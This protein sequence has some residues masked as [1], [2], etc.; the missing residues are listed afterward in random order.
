MNVRCFGIPNSTLLRFGNLVF[1]CFLAISQ[2]S[3]AYLSADKK[4]S[5][6]SSFC[7][8]S[9]STRKTSSIV[10]AKA[11]KRNPTSETFKGTALEGHPARKQQGDTAESD[12]LLRNQSLEAGSGGRINDSMISSDNASEIKENSMAEPVQ[13]YDENDS[14]RLEDWI[15]SKAFVDSALNK[16]KKVKMKEIKEQ[17]LKYFLDSNVTIRIQQNDVSDVEFNKILEVPKDVQIT[18][19]STR[20]LEVEEKILRAEKTL[21]KGKSKSTEPLPAKL[22]TVSAV[23]QVNSPTVSDQIQSNSYDISDATNLGF[24]PS[25]VAENENQATGESRFQVQDPSKSEKKLST[26]NET[27]MKIINPIHI[28]R[29]TD[30]KLEPEQQGRQQQQQDRFRTNVEEISVFS[31]STR[32][33]CPLTPQNLFDFAV[34]NEII[35]QNEKDILTPAKEDTDLKIKENILEEND[36]YYMKVRKLNED[37][38]T[39]MNHKNNHSD[40][41]NNIND[42]NDTDN[43]GINNKKE[44]NEELEMMKIFSGVELWD[45]GMMD[46]WDSSE[47][48][49]FSDLRRSME[50][51]SSILI[52]PDPMLCS[53]SETIVY[54]NIDIDIDIDVKTSTNVSEHRDNDSKKLN[55]DRNDYVL[56]K[57]KGGK[58]KKEER[59]NNYE[60][61]SSKDDYLLFNCDDKD[62][63][64][65]KNDEK[66]AGIINEDEKNYI[67]TGD[68]TNNILRN[69]SNVEN[70][71]NK[72]MIDRNDKILKVL[73]ELEEKIISLEDELQDEKHRSTQLIQA[74]LKMEIEQDLLRAEFVQYKMSH[75]KDVDKIKMIED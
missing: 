67:P 20:I 72:L 35:I 59:N 40:S 3:Y 43:I 57:R 45:P 1:L 58:R 74:F 54:N 68:I 32:T 71:Y 42:H 66:S 33:Y 53:N 18:D 38:T 41:D 69:K 7:S 15:D 14:A 9:F 27:A 55:F 56:E 8:P 12:N 73:L 2:F 16:M 51:S 24:G 34:L 52:A 10:S 62:E 65:N 48:N 61:I 5:R 63:N 19:S 13:A 64:L 23:R 44:G 36:I 46:P 4:Q 11:E 47:M 31:K 26:I 29:K 21:K 37:N 17:S 39:N 75:L 22:P 25:S 30:S 6:R 60:F 70:A 49:I 50:S 28:E